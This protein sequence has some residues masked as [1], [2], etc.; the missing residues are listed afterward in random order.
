[1]IEVEQ[2]SKTYGTT[3][4][5]QDVTFRVEKGDFSWVFASNQRHGADCGI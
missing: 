4:A 5:I 2:L 1:M 3:Q